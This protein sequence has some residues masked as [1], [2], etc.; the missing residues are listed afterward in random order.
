MFIIWKKEKNN[1]QSNYYHHFLVSW[2]SVGLEH[3]SDYLVGLFR[4][5]YW[6]A[7][8]HVPIRW[9]DIIDEEKTGDQEES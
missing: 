9:Y 4:R 6:V 7:V 2:S 5:N 8:L 1:I 3:D